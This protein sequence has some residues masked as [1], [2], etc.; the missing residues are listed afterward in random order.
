MGFTCSPTVTQGVAKVHTTAWV[1]KAGLARVLW[2]M[3]EGPWAVGLGP[4]GSG[5]WAQWP[6]LLRKT[7]A[8]CLQLREGLELAALGYTDGPSG[9]TCQAL[10]A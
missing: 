10:A 6:K 5:R 3:P 1:A 7:R 2:A 9:G 8:T 4:L